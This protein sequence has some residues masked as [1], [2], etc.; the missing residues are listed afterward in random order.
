MLCN[1]AY[2]AAGNQLYS[3]SH[4]YWNTN[5]KQTIVPKQ[6]VLES[7]TGVAALFFGAVFGPG[8]AARGLNFL[9]LLSSFGN[10]VSNL[11]GSSRIIRE[12]GRQVSQHLLMY[13]YSH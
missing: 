1:I 13:F 9:V 7:G 3:P 12:C 6:D 5:L 10:L 4:T 2:F 11:I 8:N